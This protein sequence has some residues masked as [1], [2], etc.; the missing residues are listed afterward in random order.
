MLNELAKS[1]SSS[2]GFVENEE[3]SRFRLSVTDYVGPDQTTHKDPP[4]IRYTIHT[5][6]LSIEAPMIF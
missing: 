2:F 1:A 5:K 3:S 4:S 6:G